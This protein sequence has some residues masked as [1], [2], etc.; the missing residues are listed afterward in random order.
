[1]SKPSLWLDTNVAWSAK[2]VRELAT[3]ARKKGVRVVVHAQVHL[4]IWRQRNVKDGADFDAQLVDSYLRQLG[5]E[6]FDAMLDRTAA[7]RWGER[8]ARRY[9]KGWPD[10]KL[11][12][13]KARLPG[14]TTLPARRVPMTT[15]WLVALAVEDHDGFI[16]V[17][18][19]GEEWK[20]LREALPKRALSLEEC[21]AWLQGLPDERVP[22]ADASGR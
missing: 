8:L 2:D 21:H 22:S 14:G 20:G 3:L 16:A 4:E 17:E 9:E 7:E 13:V 18:D 15:D 10:A 19:K 5:I 12:A 1:M 11:S 6:V